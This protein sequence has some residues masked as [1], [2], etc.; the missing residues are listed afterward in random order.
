MRQLVLFSLLLIVCIC[1]YDIAN[2]I[3]NDDLALN[4]VKLGTLYPDH[5]VFLGA[6]PM[7]IVS[8][9]ELEHLITS[10]DYIKKNPVVIVRNSG[11]IVQ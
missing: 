4:I 8:I 7:Q 2:D 9:E 10:P 6:D 5:V 3:A 1:K 11:V